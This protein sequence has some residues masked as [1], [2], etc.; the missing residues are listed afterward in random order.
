[1]TVDQ[2]TSTVSIDLFSAFGSEGTFLNRHLITKSAYQLGRVVVT[3]TYRA[4]VRTVVD[5]GRDRDLSFLAGGIAFFAFFSIIPAIT[6]LIALG[7]LVGGEAF[8]KQL[9]TLL[10]LYLADEGLLLLD[11]ALTNPT[12]LVGASLVGTVALFWSMAKVFRAIDIAF[13]RIYNTETTTSLPRQL[14]HAAVVIGAIGVG[15]LLL[16]T[17]QGLLL[18]FG[19][20]IPHAGVLFIPIMLFGLAIIFTPLY[21]VMPPRNIA[22]REALPGTIVAVL[23]LLVLQQTFH[24]YAANAGQYQAYGIVGAVLLFLLWLYLGSMILL[25]GAVV[26]VA[27]AADTDDVSGSSG[28]DHQDRGTES[29]DDENNA[30]DRSTDPGDHD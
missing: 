29:I 6:V 8:V 15:F 24:I 3:T 1:M 19:D 18:W 21:Y 11:E 4:R 5:I 26:N 13:D 16:V 17:I 7:S 25:L 20:H 22:F 14:F 28:I 10:E 2:H 27:F 12:G 23:G 30:V 9:L